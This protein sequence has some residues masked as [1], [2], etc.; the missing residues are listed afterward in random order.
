MAIFTKY[1]QSEM[2]YP[3]LFDGY[4]I[5]T[6]SALE[7]FSG[8]A[9]GQVDWAITDRLHV[10]GDFGTTMTRKKLILTGK[11]TGIR[12]NRSGPNRS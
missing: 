2:E 7:T 12:N 4:G 1:H 8:A 9:F 11:L 6:N 5:K 10:L 3:G